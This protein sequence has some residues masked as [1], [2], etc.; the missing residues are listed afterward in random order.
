MNTVGVVP[1]LWNMGS[2]PSRSTA[3]ATF[4]KS[5]GNRKEELVFN[6]HIG[7]LEVMNTVE[8]HRSGREVVTAMNKTDG[9]GFFVR[10]SMINWTITRNQLAHING[11]SR[12]NQ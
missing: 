7:K 3:V 11:I 12:R 10:V 5:G 2:A 4:L 9:G 6:P 1:K 8:A